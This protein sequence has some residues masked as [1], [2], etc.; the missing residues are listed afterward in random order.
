MNKFLFSNKAQSS[1]VFRLMVEGIIGLVIL[2]AILGMLVYFDSLSVSVSNEKIYKTIGTALQQPD[3]TTI[4]SDTLTIQSGAEYSTAG[5]QEK[6]GY[7]KECFGLYAANSTAKK[8]GPLIGFTFDNYFESIKFEIRSDTRLIVNCNRTN[9]NCPLNNSTG[10]VC[11][12]IVCLV[13][14]GK[15]NE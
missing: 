1:T 4:M 14:F 3:G 10:V 8:L 2:T 6:T 7:P 15:K 13:S 11:C 9:N 5:L 12:D